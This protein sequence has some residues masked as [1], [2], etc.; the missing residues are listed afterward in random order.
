MKK[1]LTMQ[2]MLGMALN[3]TLKE[4]YVKEYRAISKLAIPE[5]WR[6]EI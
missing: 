5:L 4:N 1:K 6:Q 3:A 2:I